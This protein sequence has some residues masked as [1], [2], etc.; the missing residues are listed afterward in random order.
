MLCS[1]SSIESVTIRILSYRLG[2][3]FLSSVPGDESGKTF[4]S[5]MVT[6]TTTCSKSSKDMSR[7]AYEDVSVSMTTTLG[8]S[9]VMSF[10]SRKLKLLCT[11]TGSAA[12][13]T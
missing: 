11:L 4:L 2:G 1:I 12:S 3:E 13:S 10:T 8:S 6:W 5:D 7:K 9:T